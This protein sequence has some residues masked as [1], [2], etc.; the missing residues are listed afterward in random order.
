[1][2]AAGATPCAP[3]R[4]QAQQRR[5]IEFHARMVPRPLR[6]ASGYGVSLNDGRS[7]WRDNSERPKREQG[8]RADASMVHL[9]RCCQH[10]LDGALILCRFHVDEIDDDEAADIEQAV[11]Q[12]PRAS[13]RRFQVG[14]ARGASMSPPRVLLAGVG[15]RAIPAL[16]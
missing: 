7:R 13:V 1:M 3:P 8:G 6:A 4:D 10:V 5:D 16:G 14:I 2:D 12:L 15:C 9:D 11:N